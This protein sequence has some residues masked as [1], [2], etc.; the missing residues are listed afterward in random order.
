MRRSILAWSV[1]LL[2]M[3]GVTGGLGLYKYAEIQAGMAAG[4]ARPEPSEA[5]ATARAT[6]A[7]WAPTTRAIGTVTAR[8]QLELRN[9]I[10]GLIAARG[11]SSGDTVEK[12]QLLI[13]LD[14]RQ[15]QASLAAAE[16]EA[17]LARANLDRREALRNSPAFSIQDFDKSRE[18]YA[19]AMA[20]AESLKVVIDR[21]RIV[22][23][24][25]ARV[26]ITDLQP[27]SYLDAGTLIVRLQ[28]V[29]DHVFIDF[30]L[31][32]EAA[33][34]LHPGDEVTV[35]SPALPD[36]VRKVEILAED[37]SVDPTSRAV[38]FRALGAG[39][40]SHLRPGA[41]VDVIAATATP[42]SRVV[43]PLT[44]V[45]RSPAGQH[46]FVIEAIEGKSRARERRVETGAVIADNVVIESGLAAG[47]R[48]ATAGSFKLRDG[49][50]IA[51][52]P[53]GG[54]VGPA[55]MN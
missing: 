29:D 33:A 27:G 3:G 54:G 17:R 20:R 53:E 21:K 11:F 37:D 35:T 6:E 47:E 7:L 40:G 22:A 48:V 36:G 9:E 32:Q 4:A 34:L 43:V 13:Q 39:L 2:L 42:K 23:P 24:F 45:R 28:G 51:P 44:A 10:A 31:P 25:K 15:E 38:R 1:L 16:A 30:A 8:Q 49:M 50:L 12:G 55:A 46:V 14:D 18:D 5:V 19:A 41:F 26:G 52:E